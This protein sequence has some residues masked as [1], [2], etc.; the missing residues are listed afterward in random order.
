MKTIKTHHILKAYFVFFI[1]IASL[2]SCNK[3]DAPVV[4]A[5]VLSITP[6]LSASYFQ[7][8]ESPL[9]EVQWN[10]DRGK[11]GLEN[12]IQGLSID[13]ET[14]ELSW[15][16]SLP[17]GVHTVILFAYNEA[18]KD[19]ASLTINNPF[20][21]TFKGTYLPSTSFSNILNRTMEINFIIDG[22]LSG[23][24][25]T[26]LDDG[27]ILEPN[28]FSGN[29]VLLDTKMEGTFE[30]EDGESTYP[31]D[32]DLDQQGKLTGQYSAEFLTVTFELNV[33]IQQ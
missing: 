22:T 14:G 31:F 29:Y 33:L 1:L 25:Q 2:Q 17:I 9:P 32:A 3:D 27:T 30:Y 6:N 26:E 10:G 15:D 18:G 4:E 21:G 8:G 16:P 12:T 13:S 19:L 5:P 23:Y 28:Y 11:F 20:Q 24:T 7:Q